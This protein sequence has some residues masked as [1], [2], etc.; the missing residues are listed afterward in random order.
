MF[1]DHDS[2][3]EVRR[4]PR[5]D[6]RPTERE[7]TIAELADAFVREPELIRA[8]LQGIAQETP[9]RVRIILAAA[10]TAAATRP[11]YADLFYHAGQAAVAAGELDTAAAE[12]QRAVELNPGYCDALILAAQVAVQQSQPQRAGQLLEAALAHGADYPDV[13]MLLGNVRRTLGQ[14]ELARQAYRRAGELNPQL[15]AA[16]AALTAL[17]CSGASGKSDEL[18]A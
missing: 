16:Q 8:F 2:H 17:S 9:E 6:R 1:N 7:R 12:L 4:P 15:T 13:H 3:P 18:P 5:C 10:Q 14:F 11:K